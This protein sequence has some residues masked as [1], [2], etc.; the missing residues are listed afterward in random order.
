[1]GSLEIA[2]GEFG[3]PL[4]LVLGHQR[5]GAIKFAMKKPPSPGHVASIIEYIKPAVQMAKGQSG[6]PW[7]NTAK[8][9]VKIVVDQ[10]KTSKPILTQYMEDR[11]LKIVGAYY[12]LDN[13]NVEIIVP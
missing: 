3:V 2:V 9:N 4:I 6:D 5:C 13:C 10:L 12:W 8:A 11:R 7:D 1:M